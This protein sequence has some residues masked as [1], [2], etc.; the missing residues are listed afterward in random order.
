VGEVSEVDVPADFERE[1]PG[2]SRSASLVAANLIRT[3]TALQAAIERPPRDGAGLSIS[4][5]QV[6]A[7]VDGADEPPTAQAIAEQLLV[8]SG[9]MTSL[10][11]TLER[12]DLVERRRH[13]SDRRKILIHLT[14]QGQ[15]T[16]DHYLPAIHGTIHLVMTGLTEPERKQ[17]LAALAKV[18]AGLIGLANQPN[19]TVKARRKRRR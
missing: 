19:P 17:L 10:L 2:A 3:A 6:L 11:D 4:A 9:S 8:T 7:I 14:D 16:V 18:R 13:P 12:R 1:F 15:Q 5:F